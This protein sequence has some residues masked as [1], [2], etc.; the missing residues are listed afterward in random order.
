M[1]TGAGTFVL[2]FE[3]CAYGVSARRIYEH[4]MLGQINPFARS[5]SSVRSSREAAELIDLVHGYPQ[6][7]SLTGLTLAG[8]H[9]AALSAKVLGDDESAVRSGA[10]RAA[11]QA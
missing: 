6:I 3:D 5:V 7:Y 10:A 4:M 1:F 9:D 2:D 11:V 8:L